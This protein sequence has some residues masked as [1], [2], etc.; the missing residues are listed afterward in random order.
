LS[1]AAYY[2]GR[3][4]RQKRQVDGELVAQLVLQQRAEH[5]RIG[6]RKLRVLLKEPLDEAGVKIGRDRMFSELRKRDLLVKP[7][8]SAYPRTTC[9]RHSLPIFKNRI[10]DMEVKR[11]NEVWVG[12]LTYLRSKEGYQF[13]ALLTDKCTRKIVGYHCADTLEAQ[14]CCLALEMALAELPEGAKPIHHS[15]RGSQ[16]CCHQY[17]SR[18]TERG[19]EVSMT[20]IDHTAENALAE[21]INGILKQEYYLDAEFATKEQAREAAK[22]AIYLYN[23]RRPHLALNYAVPA[24][25]HSLAA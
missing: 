22:Q 12:D 4:Q 17:V 10:K 7:R 3:K 6:T 25:V 15:D 16:Y 19:L 11:A 23:N 24:L 20:E 13:L 14:G 9:S 8:R 18:L 1:R 5:P 21:R 2:K